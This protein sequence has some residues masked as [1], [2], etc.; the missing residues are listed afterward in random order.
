[1]TA[2]ALEP[3][4]TR[5]LPRVPREARATESYLYPRRVRGATRGP[6]HIDYSG[7]PDPRLRA[8][9]NHATQAINRVLEL[10][11]GWD[12]RRARRISPLAAESAVYVLAQL[13]DAHSAVPQ[14]V[15]LPDGG[16][17]LEWHAAG[18]SLEIEIDGEGTAY[19]LATDENGLE[20]V[21]ATE[22]YPY[23]SPDLAAARRFLAALSARVWRAQTETRRATGA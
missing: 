18:N 3:P 16:L 14:V 15:P 22:T 23:H 11:D 12:G 7:A 21:D 20:V 4:V 19:L 2:P 1:M 13:L 9:F 6:L 10:P 8:L 17:Q 5:P